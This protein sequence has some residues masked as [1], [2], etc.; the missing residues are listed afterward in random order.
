MFAISPS[1]ALALSLAISMLLA[2][3]LRY[4]AA[5]ERPQT[6]LR[7]WAAAFACHAVHDA[8]LLAPAL[9]HLPLALLANDTGFGWLAVFLVYLAAAG[10]ALLAGAG[11]A[12]HETASI[13]TYRQLLKR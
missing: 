13:S 7:A 8:A 11:L 10:L 1:A 12:D 6:A 4:V 3:S 5:V 9:T 2:A